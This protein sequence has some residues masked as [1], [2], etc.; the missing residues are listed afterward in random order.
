MNSN[1]EIRCHLRSLPD[2]RGG[3]WEAIS[4]QANWVLLDG[5]PVHLLRHLYIFKYEARKE[6]PFLMQE[7][8][9]QEEGLLAQEDLP[10]VPEEELQDLL[11]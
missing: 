5:I 10:L 2:W 8:S 7:E 4:R 11:H 3:A 1:E 6:D 9:V